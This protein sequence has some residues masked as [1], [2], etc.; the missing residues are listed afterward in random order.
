[1]KRIIICVMV[2]MA[3]QLLQ[4]QSM[5]IG[6]KGAYNTTWLMNKNILIRAMN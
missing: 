6:V 2:L 4:S 1:M 5:M 3:T